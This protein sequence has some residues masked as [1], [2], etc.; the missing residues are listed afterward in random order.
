MISGRRLHIFRAFRLFAA[1][2]F[3][4]VSISQFYLGKIERRLSWIRAA[5]QG[6]TAGQA[7]F[8][9]S[10]FACP[11]AVYGSNRFRCRFPSPSDL[12]S[13][14]R[15]IFALVFLLFRVQLPGFPEMR[16]VRLGSFFALFPLLLSRCGQDDHSDH[17]K[18]GNGELKSGEDKILYA[19][20]GGYAMV[21]LI[22]AV[23]SPSA[24][25]APRRL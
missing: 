19:H 4:P 3:T 7:Y 16:H 22:G 11:C 18:C 1:W 5:A 17:Q 25:F 24:P 13:G 6:R 20:G 2:F 23:F 12:V 14:R 8:D 15:G 10:P 9:L 21:F